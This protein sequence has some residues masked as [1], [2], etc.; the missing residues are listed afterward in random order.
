MAQESGPSLITSNRKA[1]HDY[2]ILETF[3]AGLVL[4]GTEVKS[5]RA[6][7]ASLAEAYARLRGDEVWLIG[8]HIPEY[9]HGNR[10]NHEPTRARKLLLHRREIERLR[11]QIEQKGLTLVPLR[12]Y[13]SKGRAK[14]EF[15]LGRGKKHWDK[16]ED[17][18][19]R[20]A[21]RDMDRALSR[22]TKGDE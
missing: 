20:E 16:R 11:G 6:G 19:K 18:A 12:L 10:E 4:T 8:A 9:S 5:L 14:L 17:T 7:K 21:Q 3:E 2:E 13:W 1:R 15:A 22:R